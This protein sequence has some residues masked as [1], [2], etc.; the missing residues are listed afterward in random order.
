MHYYLQGQKSEKTSF[1]ISYFRATTGT[2]ILWGI[3]FPKQRKEGWWFVL[4]SVTGMDDILADHEACSGACDLCIAASQLWLP[5]R[6]S[7]PLT[8]L[9]IYH[10]LI[11][12]WRQRNHTRTVTFSSFCPDIIG[13]W[14]AHPRDVELGSPRNLIPSCTFSLFCKG[15]F[16]YHFLKPHQV[17]C[18]VLVSRTL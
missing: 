14:Q 10:Q 13:S 7:L 4:V 1:S 12:F 5:Y 17:A 16:R 9:S 2:S 3:G 8:Y 11:L 15:L 18:Y 6:Y